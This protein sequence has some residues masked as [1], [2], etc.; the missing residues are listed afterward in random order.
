MNDIAAL[1]Q[2]AQAELARIQALPSI[3]LKDKLAIQ[4]Q[5]AAELDP[6]ARRTTMDETC[7][8]YTEAQARVEASR[9]MK[10]KKPFCTAACPIGMP[11]PQ[12]L[13]R[14]AE[15][16]FQ[17]AIDII[18]ATSLIPS[19]CSR[20]CPH[21]KQC[22]SNCAMGKSLKDPNKGLHLGN[23]ERFCA[24]YE[25]EHLGGKKALPVAPETGK[26]VAVIGAGPAG[27]GCAIDLRC[28]GHHVEIFDA[29][30]QLGG[31]LRYGIPEF[32]LPKKILDYELSIL[33]EM[34]IECHSGI[35]IGKETS[36][37]DLFN[38]GFDAVFIGNGAGKP[39][40]TG[41]EGETLKGV[42]TAK[43][44][45]MLANRGEKIDSGKNVIVVGGGNVA[46]DAARMAFRLGAET[47]HIVYRRTQEEMPACKA[48]IHET[49]EEGVQILELH[50][51]A[52][53]IA[54]ENGRVK[55]A[56]LDVFELGAPDENGR[57]TPVKIEGKSEV[58]DC[59]TVVVAVGSK[60]SDEIS[61]YT[62][63]LEVKHNSTFAVKNEE[64]GETTMQNVYVGGD[65]KHGPKTVVLA[66]KTG[67]DAAAAIHK[68]LCGESA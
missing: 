35:R 64:S 1:D 23:M 25:R 16:D 45:L 3:T 47:V 10:C 24:D 26:K 53:Y 32:R 18:R 6:M 60:V 50:N 36:V 42:F 41:V 13:E 62:K 66:I 58:I 12:Y 28:R 9:C 22:Q 27:I 54:D 68:A 51:P 30:D 31:V 40:T 34:G 2:A 55:Q 21:E 14:V 43:E 48:E 7:L 19:I 65:A 59:D 49:V 17:G 56:R 39:V 61:S 37:E 11:I 46:M 52:E 38:Q 33:P 63:A 67:R 8:G 57:P 29:Y 15:G 20:V 44:Y 5:Y 4:P